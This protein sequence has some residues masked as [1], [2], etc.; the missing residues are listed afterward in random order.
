MDTALRRCVLAIIMLASG[1][2]AQECIGGVVTDIYTLKMSINTPRVY[3]NSGSLGYRKYRKDNLVGE[4]H[5][6]YDAEGMEKAKISVV[7]LQNI[8][9]AINGTTV[10]YNVELDS[11]VTPRVNLIGSNLTNIFKTPSVS[12]AV[13]CDPSY[14][15]GGVEEDNTLYITLSGK[16]TVSERIRE[17]AQVIRK[18]SGNLAGAL[19]CGCSAYGH[20]SP[21]RVNGVDGPMSRVD[22]VAAVWGTWSATYKKSTFKD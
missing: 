15:I 9:Y 14:N 3:N 6:S 11:M 18:L 7:G 5:F 22:D 1:I 17:H 16:G 4:L 20:K 2:V 12:F 21:T 8:S 19:G 10:K 13:V